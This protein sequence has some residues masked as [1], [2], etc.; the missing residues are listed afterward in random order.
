MPIDGLQFVI[1]HVREA[2]PAHC[3]SADVLA[4]E[5]CSQQFVFLAEETKV[6]PGVMRNGGA[7]LQESLQRREYFV[8][9]RLSDIIC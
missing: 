6:K 1:T 3:E 7:I 9:C 5:A 4:V 8:R 2:A